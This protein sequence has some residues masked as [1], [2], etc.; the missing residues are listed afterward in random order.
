MDKRDDKYRLSIYEEFAKKANCEKVNWVVLHGN[1]GYP[2]T[3]GRDLDVLCY[4][5]DETLK[6]LRIFK[7]V[8]M[9]NS[10]TGW[11]IFPNPVWG[12]RVL[13]VSKNY[14]V[15]ELH[16]LHKISSG[17]ITCKVDYQDIY[18]SEV[19]PIN[20]QAAEFKSLVM[21][22]LGN[23]KKVLN[24]IDDNMLQELPGAVRSSV[25]HL[26]NKGRISFINRLAIYYLYR[27]TF[28][29]TMNNLYY[30]IKVKKQSFH[31]PTTPLVDASKVEYPIEQLNYILEEVFLKFV[32]GD[33]KKDKDI[34]YDQARQRLV[35]FFNRDNEKYDVQL[36]GKT[37]EE[38]AA[39][40]LNA[41]DKYNIKYRLIIGSQV[42]K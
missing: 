28:K 8:A 10:R 31:S 17:L 42:E 2:D 40:I 19:F 4:N 32:N 36:K 7:K 33:S 34:R 39:D 13:A 18:Y 30:T 23:S 1:E 26:K 38:D 27:N 20:K 6:A 14:E 22:L 3:I 9:E 24:R 41:F 5:F 35:Y 16:I 15:A 25:N 37:A 29:E 11:V 12:Y 21:P